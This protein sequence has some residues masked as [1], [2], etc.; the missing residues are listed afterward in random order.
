MIS[1]TWR[2]ACF[3]AFAIAL[4]LTILAGYLNFLRELPLGDFHGEWSALVFFCCAVLFLSPALPSRFKVNYALFVLPA[5]LSLLIGLQ[6][7]L[8]FYTVWQ[9]PGF[10]L[11]YL[12]LAMLALLLGQGIRA[13]GLAGET[14]NRIAW[15]LSIAALLNTL[16]QLIQ[17]VGRVSD[18]SPFVVPLLTCR[19][20]GNTGQSNHAATLAWLGVA[21]VLYLRGTQRLPAAASLPMLALLLISA[22]LSASRMSW[23]LAATAAVV[24]A[25]PAWPLAGRR[26]RII[27]G[28]MLLCGFVAASVA[29]APVL[30]SLGAT[31]M[32]GID[33]LAERNEAGIVYRLDFWRQSIEVWKTS[34]WI[35]VG[36]YG[37]APTVF[38][39]ENL[40]QAHA[41][42]RY[43]HNLFFSV[44]A[45][46]GIVGAAVLL[47]LLL[48]FVHRLWRVR[49]ELVASDALL[50][51]ILAVVGM[52]SLL[53]YPLWYTHFLI[54]AALA[55]GLLVRPEW[56]AS[57]A[58]RPQ[59]L[60]IVI[61]S[62]SLL[63]V[64]GFLFADYRLLD[65]VTWMEIYRREMQVPATPEV[66]QKIEEAASE[67]WL[68]GHKA[69]LVAMLGAP[70]AA[71]DLQASIEATDHMLRREVAWQ[72]M[73]RRAALS[74]LAGDEAAA[75]WHLRRML[76]FFSVKSEVVTEPL[77]WLAEHRPNEFTAL[78]P[79]LDEELERMKKLHR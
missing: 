77:Y 52:H 58:A 40:D 32:S 68:F 34:P 70:I 5:S 12:L 45:E 2:G 9:T 41:L 26:E 50:L 33:R 57:A 16:A 3:S 53:E 11:G 62:A 28:A 43:V 29:T 54:L 56:A 19:P 7:L 35:G 10:W 18:V 72:L 20:Y 24:V 23:L 64:A 42:D 73:G 21:S 74:I 63:I 6:A 78:K 14:I 30:Q 59:R 44:L 13:A 60:P 46:F 75:R 67:V 65:R 15:A 22:A 47:L 36:V 55:L 31:C 79:M 4:A 69:E 27:T 71:D 39:I 66:R 17:V 1:S 8:G 38:A 76:G 25:L 61:G 49:H 51:L 48:L 37:F